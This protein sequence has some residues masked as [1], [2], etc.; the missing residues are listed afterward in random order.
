MS[1]LISY[2]IKY[3]IVERV[4]SRKQDK[5]FNSAFIS[6]SF[7]VPKKDLS[8]PARLVINYSLINTMISSRLPT[9]PDITSILHGLRGKALFPPLTFR[10]PFIA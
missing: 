10:T 4:D 6:P 3:G 9:L 2:L 8:G 7:I 5:N 1:D